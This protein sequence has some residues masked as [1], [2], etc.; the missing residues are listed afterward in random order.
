MK[1]NTLMAGA[2]ALALILAGGAYAAGEMGEGMHH[3]GHMGMKHG[4]PAAMADHLMGHFDLNKD[5]KITKDEIMQAG[6]QETAA[7]FTAMDA[8]HDGNVTADEAYQ[9][10]AAR[11][12]EHVDEMFKRMD[13]NSDGKLTQD[14]FAAAGPMM[15]HHHGGMHDHE[16]MDDDED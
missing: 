9:A 3:R 4:D 2:G 7:H 5:G 13:K 16:G 11:M 14:E 1:R 12:R 10:H 15:M 6:K 8:N